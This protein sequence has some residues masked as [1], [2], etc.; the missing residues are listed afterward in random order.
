MPMHLLL[1]G[2]GFF[3]VGR[4]VPRLQGIDVGVQVLQCEDTAAA[5]HGRLGG[6]SGW[7]ESITGDSWWYDH[8][9]ENRRFAREPEWREITRQS[10][11]DVAVSP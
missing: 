10:P 5:P 9:W 1:S 3:A 7:R 2:F 4:I 6:L 11:L 8:G